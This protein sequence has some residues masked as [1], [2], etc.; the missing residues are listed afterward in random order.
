MSQATK[1]FLTRLAEDPELRESFK[2]DPKKLMDEYD[3]PDDHQEMIRKGDKQG[4]MEAAGAQEI[5]TD[6]LIF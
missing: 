2:A 3:V 6:L 5:D 4:V 1:L